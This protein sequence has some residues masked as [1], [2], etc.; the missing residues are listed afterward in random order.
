MVEAVGRFLLLTASIVFF[1]SCSYV[2]SCNSYV[3]SY[4]ITPEPPETATTFEIKTTEATNDHTPVYLMI[5][6]AEFSQFLL[7]DYQ[8]IAAVIDQTDDESCLA[9]VCLI[10]G[11]T[12]ILKIELPPEKSIAIYVL[13]TDPGPGWKSLIQTEHSFKRVEVLLGE[14]EIEFVKVMC[15]AEVD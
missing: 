7:D 10:P 3:M 9:S 5:K 4:F 6:T 8:E 12:K 13:F 14:H 1:S 11:G 2:A 15:D